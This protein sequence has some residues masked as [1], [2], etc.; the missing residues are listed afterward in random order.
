MI[1]IEAG[2]SGIASKAF[3]SSF[4]KM[5]RLRKSL[6]ASSVMDSSRATEFKNAFSV[7]GSPEKFLLIVWAA[8]RKISVG[9]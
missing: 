4:D 7:N 5:N 1:K 3:P 9:V 2:F 6:F 8:T